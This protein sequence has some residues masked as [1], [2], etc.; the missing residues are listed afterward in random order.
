M[1]DK[2]ITE[3]IETVELSATDIVP[4]VQLGEGDDPDVTRKVPLSEL[5][6]RFGRT[7]AD[8]VVDGEIP[9]F[10]GVDGVLLKGSG[11]PV[12]D[13][14]IQNEGIVLVG[15]EPYP[16][17]KFTTEDVTPGGD[18][19]VHYATFGESNA[20]DKRKLTEND[21]MG[22]HGFIRQIPGSML[23]GFVAKPNPKSSN[24][25]FRASSY[26]H[27]T[28]NWESGNGHDETDVYFS[29]IA[30]S[31]AAV[32]IDKDR[33]IKDIPLMVDF[34]NVMMKSPI[35][36][37]DLTVIGVV[38]GDKLSSTWSGASTT[39]SELILNG[40][41][42]TT[43]N[44]NDGVGW[45]ITGGKAT[46][47]NQTGNEESGDNLKQSVTLVANSYYAFT[48]TVSG[49]SKGD[50][51]PGLGT[52]KGE[53]V[54]DNGT[55]TRYIQAPSSGSVDAILKA[56]YKFDG[57]V[58][59][60]SLIEC[61]DWHRSDHL[62]V[63]F[64]HNPVSGSVVALENTS[65]I[66]AGETYL[67]IITVGSTLDNS[68]LVGSIMPS[69]GGVDGVLITAKGTYKQII[70]ASTTA[71]FKVTPSSDFNGYVQTMSV[72]KVSNGNVYA[73]NIRARTAAGLQLS[74]K[75]GTGGL[76]LTDDGKI[77]Y[78][79]SS[80][81]INVEFYSNNTSTTPVFG[82]E[83]DGNG[84]AGLRLLLT[85]LRSY[86]MMI[87]NSDTSAGR[88]L[89]WSASSAGVSDSNW[90]AE[91]R[92]TGL[93]T[94]LAHRTLITAIATPTYARTGGVL[95][96]VI[97]PVG[98]IGTGEDNLMS[99]SIEANVL[100]ANGQS[101]EIEAAGTF[102]ANSNTKRLKLVWGSTTL[103][104]TTALALNS[105][106]WHLHCKMVRTGSG[107]QVCVTTIRSSNALLPSLVA[108]VEAT[109]DL[110]IAHTLKLTL[111]ATADNDGVN[112]MLSVKWMPA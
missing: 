107:N 33:D 62:H 103:I 108:V 14:L 1:A 60:V 54:R 26:P 22:I 80:P 10:D 39:G 89:R 52:S 87:D 85:G 31:V 7:P 18:G 47:T 55:Y 90:I 28:F 53:I 41:F 88:P 112:K 57:S 96:S 44:W 75:A 30:K 109:E 111:A 100:S 6:A 66:V 16:D 27:G 104:D 56:S 45:T 38:A 29:R 35:S 70:T 79:T 43:A 34:A 59:N 9:T 76:F 97:T 77:G 82:I 74:N 84:D 83:Q 64:V 58:D 110:T 92:S 3:L 11:V 63:G 4:I 13:G 93:F 73:D 37:G 12:V 101:L 72:R 49:M 8:S 36:L 40:D 106:D 105:G 102:A 94:N 67:V 48:F 15:K 81:T 65:G 71:N 17:Y 98:N 42:A 99:S 50:L 20:H 91:L 25:I 95:F 24:P 23:E 19:R 46:H 51:E 2:K 68:T 5:D 21:I 69:V 61:A 32:I 78:G 86:S